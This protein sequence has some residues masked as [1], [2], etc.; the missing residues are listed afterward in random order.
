MN[1]SRYAIPMNFPLDA[2]FKLLAIASQISLA[3][4]QGTLLY[5]V[6]QKAFKLKEAVT[7]F[8]D[9][10]QTRPLFRIEADRILDISARYRIEDAGGAELGALQRRGMKSFWRT[11]YDVEVGGRTV[12]TI[13]EENPWTKVLDGLFGSIPI[14]GIFAGYLFHPAYLVSP[15]PDGPTVL[16]VVKKPA[17]LEGRFQIDRLQSSSEHVLEVAVV[18]VLMMLLLERSRG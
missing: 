5:Y 1:F 16:R 18:S 9:E 11:H 15:A 17:L 4:A 12:L 10:S 8:G 7:V 13:R 3:D 14:L 2:R 6:K